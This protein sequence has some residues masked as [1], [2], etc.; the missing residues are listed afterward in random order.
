MQSSCSVAAVRRNGS[1]LTV[2]PG[3]ALCGLQGLL[4][5]WLPLAWAG[6]RCRAW[7]G[8]AVGGGA[9]WLQDPLL[10]PLPPDRPVDAD[11]EADWRGVRERVIAVLEAEDLARGRARSRYPVFEPALT[12]GEIAEAEAQCGVALPGGYRSFLA[13][14]GAGGPGP[15][16]RLTSLRRVGGRW[17]WVWDTFSD[18]LCILDPGGPFTETADWAGQQAAALRAAG[19][20]PGPPDEDDGYLADYR[21]AFGGRAG[22]EAWY[23]QRERAGAHQQQRVRDDQLAHRGR[24]APRRAPSPGLRRQ[25]CLQ[26]AG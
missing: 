8:G 11:A 14:V 13:Q 2:C 18:H 26:A 22:E 7:R 3:G 19:Y 9:G 21:K 1:R 24:P 16:L 20:E 4:A 12:A 15:E 6:C 10:L 5:L 17:G 25:S 23:R